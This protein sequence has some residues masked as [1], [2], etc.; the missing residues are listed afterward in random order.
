MISLILILVLLAGGVLA[1][2]FG[3]KGA[4]PRWISLAACAVD[5][6]LA[7]A[8]WGRAVAA[9]SGTRWIDE[10]NLE[11]IPGLWVRFHLA[12]DGMSLL[13]ILLTHRLARE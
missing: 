11:W 4:W 1:W 10:V 6:G 2:I 3:R 13:L 8:L 5:L 9:G 12:A 7:L